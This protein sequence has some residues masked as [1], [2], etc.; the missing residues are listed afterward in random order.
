MASF[1]RSHTSRPE[2]RVGIDARERGKVLMISRRHMCG[3][4]F[5][6]LLCLG[7]GGADAKG[8][9]TSPYSGLI[10]SARP[11]DMTNFEGGAAYPQGYGPY[12]FLGY[13]KTGDTVTGRVYVVFGG[14]AGTWVGDSGLGSIPEVH[15]LVDGN[16]TAV[17]SGGSL[18]WRTRGGQGSHA[19]QVRLYTRDLEGS[20]ACYLDSAVEYVVV[21]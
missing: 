2:P 14:F 4:A 3:I 5:G 6:L 10:S 20:R 9:S 13:P 12:V 18:L 17:S 16:V 11:C 1:L 19:L 7:A 21:Q 15:L 8:P